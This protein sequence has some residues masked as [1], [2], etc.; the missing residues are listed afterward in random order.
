[1][2]K[3]DPASQT[4][5]ISLLKDIVSADTIQ[6][7]QRAN[8]NEIKSLAFSYRGLK[9]GVFKNTGVA[10]N[11]RNIL[12]IAHE[13]KIAAQ[14]LKPGN[15]KLVHDFYSQG[16]SSK[17]SSVNQKYNN[18][19]ENYIDEDAIGEI[20]DETDANQHKIPE[21]MI[22]EDDGQNEP[23]VEDEDQDSQSE[24]FEAMNAG[25]NQITKSMPIFQMNNQ[26]NQFNGSRGSQYGP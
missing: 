15:N 22:F 16:D 10:L 6:K 23:L 11:K 4:S 12:K 3:F 26:G 5:E 1:M 2:F 19:N 21:E 9:E 20:T 8:L 14:T 7:F 13:K 25:I 17:F 18:Q 24:Y